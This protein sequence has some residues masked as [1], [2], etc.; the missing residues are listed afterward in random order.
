MFYSLSH[1]V[2]VNHLLLSYDK[3]EVLFGLLTARIQVRVMYYD[4]SIFYYLSLDKCYNL[5]GHS[6]RLKSTTT[7]NR[8]PFVQSR[9]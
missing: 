4:L 8:T 9:K 7:S 6:G 3:H 5:F 2:A 1:F